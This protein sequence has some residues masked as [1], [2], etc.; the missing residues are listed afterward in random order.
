MRYPLFALFCACLTPL[1]AQESFD[2]LTFHQAPKPL[3]EG[4]VTADWPRFLGPNDDCTTSE[5]HLLAEIP[6]GGLSIV[7]EVE[8]GGGYTCPAIVG[9]RLV[10]FHNLNDVDIVEC[11]HPETGKRYWEFAYENPYRDRY[12]FSNGPRASPVI[13][14]D[15]VYTLSASSMLHCLD[16]KTGAVIWK[17]DLEADYRIGGLFFG[18]GPTPLVYQDQVIVPVGGTQGVAVVS[19]KAD[20]GDVLW[21][22]P[23]DAWRSSY[24]S[25]IVANFHGE[26]RILAYLG[27]ESRPSVGGLL[28]IDPKTGKIDS[29][30]PW[31]ASKYESVNAATPLV[32]PNNRI[33]ISETYE[34]G[35]VLLEVDEKFKLQP[36][37]EAQEFKLHWT[38][39]IYE[40]GYFYAFTGRNEPDANLD[41]WNAQTGDREWQENI[42]W[43]YQ[44][45]NKRF[46]GGFFRGSVLEADDRYYALGEFGTLAILDLNPKKPVV[47]SQ[48]DLFRARESWTLPAISKGLLYVAQNALDVESGSESRLICYD[49]R[50]SAGE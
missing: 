35:A 38:T 19:L 8:R 25:P 44:V 15:R 45:E 50:R 26:D 20:S 49:F 28:L 10:N 9:D 5:T 2:R 48:A 4:A 46:A 34:K 29:S 18:H 31:R 17:K 39:P 23:H 33:L 13:D 12:G 22:A 27:G 21:E 14:K 30:F 43:Y 7:W 36:V 40:D 47:K 6:Q 11:L 32:I 37:W 3:P 42:M 41:C 1:S 16:L 24:A